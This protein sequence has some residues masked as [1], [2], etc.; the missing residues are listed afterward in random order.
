MGSRAKVKVVG[1][2]AF[3][4][5]EDGARAF[6]PLEHLCE[7]LRRFNLDVDLDVVKCKG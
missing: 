6:I 4:E 7:A 1:R 5:T 2:S 3:I